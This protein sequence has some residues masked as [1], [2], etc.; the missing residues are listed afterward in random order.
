MSD[1]SG[2]RVLIVNRYMGIY[3]GAEIVVKELASWFVA[4]GV[5]TRVV[6]LNISPEVKGLCKGIDIITPRRQFPYCYRSASAFSALGIINEII[7]LRGMAARHAAEF[8]C[9]N[10]HNFP[11]EWACAGLGKPVVWMCNEVPDF[12]NSPS[13]SAVIRA[14]R[15]LGIFID[16]RVTA[17]GIDEVCVADDFNAEH[18]R[19]RYQREAQIIPYGIDHDFFSRTNRSGQDRWQNIR[20]AFGIVQVGVISPE[21][22]QLE[23]VKAIESLRGSIPKPLLILAG[24]D[25]SAYALMLKRYVQEHG[26]S[27]IV[28]FTG[29]LNREDVA[30]L[31]H[32]SKVAVFPVKTQG[33]WL[34]PFEAL[35]A[36]IPV[37][38][39]QSMGAASVIQGN[40]LGIVTSEY[41]SAIAKVYAQYPNHKGLTEK[42]SLWVKDNLS[43]GLFA[44]RLLAVCKKSAEKRSRL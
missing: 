40:G 21:K 36:G 10:A 33:G 31:Y 23:S 28:M 8:D 12:Y 26:L 14:Y 43:W 38:V 18:V 16:R 9:I 17:K 37:I 3:G 2:L 39:S 32:A 4:H 13:L 29:Q 34:A 1:Y 6:T 42:S 19:K 35:S 22:N 25:K 24:N 30:S 44:E 5:K 20:E 7:A 11:A 27:D 15:R 41:S